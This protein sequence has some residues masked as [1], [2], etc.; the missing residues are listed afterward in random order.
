L[1]ENPFS[2]I[3]SGNRGSMFLVAALTSANWKI[4]AKIASKI[5]ILKVKVENLLIK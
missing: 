5:Y 4:N 1:E 3:T 2:R